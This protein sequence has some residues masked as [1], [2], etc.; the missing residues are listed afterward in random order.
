MALE[1][2]V[3]RDPTG[4]A[5][6]VEVYPAGKRVCRFV[7]GT[8]TAGWTDK[9][10]DY[11]CEGVDDQVEIN[12]AIQA[13]PNTGGEVIML[14]GTYSISDQISVRREH[15]ALTGCGESTVI[16]A[17]TKKTMI[18]ISAD[19]ALI[20]NMSLVG[21]DAGVDSGIRLSSATGCRIENVRIT[22]IRDLSSTKAYAIHHGTPTH[23]G[24]II[25][26]CHISDCSEGISSM[27]QQTQIMETHVESTV[28]S[29]ISV[30][31]KN[32]IIMGN[33]CLNSGLNGIYTGSDHCV[34]Q[35]NIC[36]GFTKSGIRAV[37]L[38]NV[39][40]NNVCMVGSGL[41][42]DYGEE[43]SPIS[44][45]ATSSKNLMCGNYVPGKDCLD[46]GTEN[47]YVNNKK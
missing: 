28:R 43:Q 31:N 2:I 36:V 30:Y 45:A 26:R 27:A 46:E 7:V 35:G 16:H 1:R 15:V 13:L 22:G 14:D 5:R 12:A 24:L 20:Q 4:V 10:C 9:D 32:C 39:I 37:G 11:L 25:R 33:V 44:T 41:P 23:V 34:I 6:T 3:I 40:S 8:S 47:T 29:C 42:E 18:R 21:S 38:G 19:R 17:T